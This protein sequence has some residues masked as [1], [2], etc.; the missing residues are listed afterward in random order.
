MK[1][2]KFEKT[3]VKDRVMRT[4]RVFKSWCDL[5]KF[6]ACFKDSQPLKYRT[7]F[8]TNFEYVLSHEGKNTKREWPNLPIKNC[9]S[10]NLLYLRMNELI[11]F[12]YTPPS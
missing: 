5:K 7:R 4:R 2:E 9:E 11:F 12:T 1:Y 6:K 3:V 8:S 10:E